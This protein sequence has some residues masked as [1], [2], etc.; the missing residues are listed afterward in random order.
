[1]SEP[2]HNPNQPSRLQLRSLLLL[3]W[4]GISSR[5]GTVG[6]PPRPY[7]VFPLGRRDM[8][9]AR[10]RLTDSSEKLR[11][12][13]ASLHAVDGEFA[14]RTTDV[15]TLPLSLATSRVSQ[16][17]GM[18]KTVALTVLKAAEEA[19]AAATTA[20]AEAV[21]AFA[22]KATTA[23]TSAAGR[24]AVKAQGM[25]KATATVT[26]KSETDPPTVMERRIPSGDNSGSN[27]SCSMSSTGMEVATSNMAV[28]VKTSESDMSDSEEQQKL[29]Q[30]DV[31]ATGGE[32]ESSRDDDVTSEVGNA[33]FRSADQERQK[34]A[35]ATLG[36]DGG[37]GKEE[38]EQ[39][40][41]E[42]EEQRE[43]EQ[44]EEEEGEEAQEG[45]E[46]NV[47]SKC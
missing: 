33:D 37:Q 23:A 7:L 45:H 47:G 24:A 41:G 46:E 12:A 36:I 17:A 5:S 43:E 8:E 10:E 27:G 13:F 32:H 4:R 35:E 29:S 16:A 42:K 19:M 14:A 15:G 31:K 40:Y 21:S 26:L 6:I 3:V 9:A 39:E 18:A 11:L 44:Q 25:A 30:H 34:E 28:A 38:E 1:M 22:I 20:R 2:R